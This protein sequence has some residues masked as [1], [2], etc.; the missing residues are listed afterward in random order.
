MMFPFQLDFNHIPDGLMQ[1]DIVHDGQRHIIFMSDL[2]KQYLAE[3]DS[4]YMDGTF[5]CVRVPFVQLFSIHAFIKCGK[6][7][8]QVPLCYVMMSR[9][10]KTDY[11][12]VF[13]AIINLL[14]TV[15]KVEE[16]VLDFEKAVWNV[17][18]QLL[19]N[20][21]IQGCWFHW[22]QAVYNRVRNNTYHNFSTNKAHIRNSV[23]DNLPSSSSNNV[24]S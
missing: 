17:I 6:A 18:R 8:K 2:Q 19:P 1:G 21:T 9:R 11:R 22:A 12:V 3:A 20:V 23:K 15:P 5:K 4:W 24:T 10:K 13:R 16:I 14:P 7:L